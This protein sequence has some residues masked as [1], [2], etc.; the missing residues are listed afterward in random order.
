MIGFVDNPGALRANDLL[1][2]IE[3]TFDKGGWLQKG[4]AM[5]H[6]PQQS[7]M[8]IHVAQAMVMDTPLLFEAGTGVGKSLAYLIPGIV[9]AVAN[10]RKLIVSSHTISLQEQL[11]NKDLKTCR[12]LFSN[13]PELKQYQDFKATLLIGKG[14]YLCPHRLQRAIRDKTD[15]FES[16]TSKELDRI[17]KWSRETETGIIQE[18]YPQPRSDVW[19]WLN[20]DS[21]QCNRRTCT[22]DTCFYQKARNEVNKADVLILNHALLFSLLGAGLNP[23]REAR[24]IL[25]PD[26]FLVLDEAHTVPN[27]ATDHFGLSVTNVGVNRLLYQLFNPKTNKGLL[28]RYH[29]KQHYTAVVEALEKAE[30]FFDQ[31]QFQYLNQRSIVRLH[32]PGWVEDLMVLPLQRVADALG[33]IAQQEQNEQAEAELADYRKRVLKY[34]ESITNAINLEKDDHVYWIERTGKNGINTGIRSAPI[35]VSPY[36]RDCLIQR[37]T[38][39]TF[40][41]ATLQDAEGMDRFAQRIGGGGVENCAVTSPFSYE[42]QMVI[43]IASDCPPLDPNH[44][45]M[46]IDFLCDTL[47]FCVSRVK[48]GTMALF[49]SYKEMNL[50]A[51]RISRDIQKQGRKLYVQGEGLSRTQIVNAVKKDGN[52]V[53]FGTDSFWTGVDIPGSALAQVVLVRIPF[54]NPSHPIIAARSDHC[55]ALGEKPFFTLTLPAAQI[56]FR[57][58]LGRLIRNQS[59]CGVLTI[60]DSRVLKKTYGHAFL[61][62][63]PHNDYSTFTRFNRNTKFRGVP[64]IF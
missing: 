45:T 52:A 14:N 64:G 13:T 5:E 62:M 59:D 1:K 30:E 9:H 42:Q 47:A 6:R 21:T 15:L 58:G 29:R 17:L 37:K 46:E 27:I 4:L 43:N 57:Q 25:Y 63:L 33:G 28:V 16:A 20:A 36:L 49:T 32:K 2:L 7:Q 39:C 8:G 24:G 51:N 18:L 55:I 56:K 60:L 3:G 44:K 22:P 41:S 34:R 35:D 53:L 19:D 61:A 10:S 54:E 26:D 48:G 50:V 40:T 12:N 23:G 31:I 38:S 11:L